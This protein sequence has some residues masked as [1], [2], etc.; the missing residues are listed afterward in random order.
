MMSCLEV[1][2]H[3]TLLLTSILDVLKSV[4]APS[5]AMD[6]YKD[7]PLHC[8]MCAGGGQI[9]GKLGV[10]W[11]PN[12]IMVSLE[13]VNHPTLYLTSILDVYEVFEHL[14]MPWMGI[15]VHPYIFYTSCASHGVQI[16]ENWG[17]GGAQVAS[18]CLL[19]L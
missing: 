7:A 17:Q 15:W 2:N 6:G 13:V 1:V 12:N 10:R 11:S 19:R 18:W 5:Y 14:H 3:P 16:L 8:Y 4:W 9:F